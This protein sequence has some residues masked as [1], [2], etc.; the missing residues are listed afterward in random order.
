MYFFHSFLKCHCHQLL[1]KKRLSLQSL[2]SYRHFIGN[3]QLSI[4]SWKSEPLTVLPFLHKTFI[5]LHLTMHWK[6]TPPTNTHIPL[7][8]VTPGFWKLCIKEQTAS[9]SVRPLEKGGVQQ[10]PHSLPMKLLCLLYRAAWDTSQL[11]KN[12]AALNMYLKWVHHRKALIVKL[13]ANSRI[14]CI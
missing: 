5:A 2:V 10:K 7:R 1:C 3:K 13:C 11:A 12:G 9:L 8:D 6:Q 4:V 14:K